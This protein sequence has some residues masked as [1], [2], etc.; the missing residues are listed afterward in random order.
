MLL[1]RSRTCG[2]ESVNLFGMIENIM[3]PMRLNP[4]APAD[5]RESFTKRMREQADAII[6]QAYVEGA[7]WMFD[8]GPLRQKLDD[9]K[10]ELAQLKKQ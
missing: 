2:A 9:L 10:A 1:K 7:L 4:N 3:S 5:V 8:E 6:R